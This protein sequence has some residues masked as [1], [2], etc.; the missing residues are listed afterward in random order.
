MSTLI[1]GGAGS[2]GTQ[3]VKNLLN[4][5][6]EIIHIASR[7]EAKHW[8]L[9]NTFQNNKKIKTSYVYE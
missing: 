7:D 3:L 6:N 9:K 4:N 5:E 2:L 8:E 1:F